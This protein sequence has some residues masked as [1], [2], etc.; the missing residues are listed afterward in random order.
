M[1]DEIR[2]SISVLTATIVRHGR[3]GLYCISVLVNTIGRAFEARQVT[4]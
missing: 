4:L 2:A 1:A 3:Q